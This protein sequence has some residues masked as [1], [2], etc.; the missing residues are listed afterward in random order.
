MIRSILAG[1][2]GP[3]IDP[4]VID[5]GIQWARRFDALLVGLGVVDQTAV[6]GAESVPLGA[7]EF[8]VHRDQALYDA[9]CRRV[10]ETQHSF[11]LQCGKAG[12]SCR[13]LEA[14][15]RSVDCILDQAQR[16]D[17]I[18]L[19]L[20]NGFP[21]DPHEPPGVTLRTVVRNTP[22]PVVA[23][24]DGWSGGGSV[25][26]AY[27]GSV[28]A[29]RTLQAF[30]G[31]GLASAYDVHLVS[32]HADEAAARRQLDPAIQYLHLHGISVHPHAV[33]TA[34]DPSTAILRQITPLDAG[35]LVMGA[36]GQPLLK[37]FLFGSVTRKV[38]A[39]CAVPVFLYH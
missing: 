33:V 12:V 17:V 35:L 1:L 5:L 14:S 34:D 30:L 20:R 38:M 21:S 9:A 3:P 29:A 4:P 11:G 10:A 36:F 18:L 26:V 39:E 24:P 6:G 37:E 13:I 25:I 31:L 27:D 8:K 16:H 32:V 7:T 2:E 19:G 15:G 22:R 28:Q 23:V